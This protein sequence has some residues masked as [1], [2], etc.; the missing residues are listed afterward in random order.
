MR[1]HG[2]RHKQGLYSKH[3]DD[4]S[5]PHTRPPGSVKVDANNVHDARQNEQNE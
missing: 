4:G 5:C 2:C 1:Q 3:N